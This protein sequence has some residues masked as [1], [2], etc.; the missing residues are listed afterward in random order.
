MGWLL[1]GLGQHLN[2]FTNFLCP[3]PIIIIGGIQKNVEDPVLMS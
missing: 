3:S 2:L 1:V